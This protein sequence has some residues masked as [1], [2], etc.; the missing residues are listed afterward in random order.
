MRSS[1]LGYW[2]GWA[3]WPSAER[4]GGFEPSTELW[5]LG[6]LSQGPFFLPLALPMVEGL[7]S[8]RPL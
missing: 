5:I 1:R 7:K 8:T 4:W 6:P 3:S 2:E